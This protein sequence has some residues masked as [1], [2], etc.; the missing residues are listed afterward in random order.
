MRDAS[1]AGVSA[2]AKVLFN[3]LN[4][5]HRVPKR[6]LSGSHLQG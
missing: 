5:D 6:L 3:D 2:Q 4:T 1:R